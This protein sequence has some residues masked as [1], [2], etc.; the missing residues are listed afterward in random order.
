MVVFT[1]VAGEGVGPVV[2]VTGIGVGSIVGC[3]VGEGVGTCVGTGVGSE[4]G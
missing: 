4:L 3:C 2:V 1:T